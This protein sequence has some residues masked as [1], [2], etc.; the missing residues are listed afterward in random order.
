MKQLVGPPHF[1]VL[2]V[3]VV[4]PVRT[5]EPLEHKYVLV[6]FFPVEPHAE[7]EH[8]PVIVKEKPLGAVTS[9]EPTGG[10]VL[11]QMVGDK[12]IIVVNPTVL[13]HV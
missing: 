3:D 12:L 5:Q 1:A 11:V 2:H 7:A 13:P 6:V 8:P 9:L 4:E 10:K